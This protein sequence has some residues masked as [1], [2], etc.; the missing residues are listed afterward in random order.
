MIVPNKSEEDNTMTN[1]PHHKLIYGFPITADS[2]LV[3]MEPFQK[4]TAPLYGDSSDEDCLNF[5]GFEYGRIHEIC[6]QVKWV[7]A[8]NLQLSTAEVPDIIVEKMKK[9]YP[10]QKLD[11]YAVIQNVYTSHY[12]YASIM[13]GYWIN[14]ND[15]TM[16][17]DKWS[18]VDDISGL[19]LVLPGHNALLDEG[20]CSFLGESLCDLSTNEDV[21]E[22]LALATQIHK[23]YEPVD[24]P[25]RGDLVNAIKDI[26]PDAKLS[27]LPV[28][29]C[30]QRVCYC[31]T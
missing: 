5:I 2:D 14:H 11:C 6:E 27:D 15:G 8:G 20:H 7:Y 29:I 4:Y 12:C 10:N 17:D 1:K 22:C 13:F 3:P 19:D 18:N 30:L 23:K 9:M 28:L 21:D 31:C 25:N 16:D 26:D 24:L